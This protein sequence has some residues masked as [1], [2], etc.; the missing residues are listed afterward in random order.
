M[1]FVEPPMRF[2]KAHNTSHEVATASSPGRQPGVEVA[3]E[4]SEPRRGGQRVSHTPGGRE[5]VSAS[6]QTQAPSSPSSAGRP[7]PTSRRGR[8]RCGTA[9]GVRI[10]GRC[11]P[12]RA[13][14]RFWL[15]CARF[16]SSIRETWN[17]AAAGF[18]CPTHLPENIREPSRS[19]DGST[20]FRLR[21]SRGT[22]GRE[23]PGGITCTREPFSGRSRR[24]LATRGSRRA[25]WLH[26][27]ELSLLQEDSSIRCICSGP[28]PSSKAPTER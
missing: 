3:K 28:L 13:N 17:P 19:G 18:I 25:S 12:T 20:S 15:I 22:R 7:D 24:Q 6:T 10:E 9:K 27:R 1:A 16:G 8:S 2:G 14:R 26:E 4:S 21:T 23:R 5:A 11:C